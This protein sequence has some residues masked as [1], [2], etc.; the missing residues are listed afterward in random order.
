MRC[1][2]PPESVTADCPKMNVPQ[3]DIHQSLQLLLICG[4][5]SRIG[6]RVGNR[7][8]QQIRNRA[9][10][11]FHCQRLVVVAFAA[12]H[13]AEHVNIGQEVHLD[14]PLSF[15]LACLAPSSWNIERKASCL[16]APLSRFRQHGVEIANLRKHSRIG[17]GIRARSAANRRLVDANDFVDKLRSAEIDLCAPGSSREP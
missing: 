14:S 6:K 15:A 3:S 16:V 12:T 10:F 4:M 2:S 7:H 5:F 1:A 17:R 11:I 9:P 13:F 8:L